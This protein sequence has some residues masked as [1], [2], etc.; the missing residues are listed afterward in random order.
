MNTLFNK[1]VLTALILGT[2]YFVGLEKMKAGNLEVGQTFPSF[3]KMNIEGVLPS[4]LSGKIVLVDFWASW[5]APCKKSFPVLE[6]LH[7][8]YGDKGVVVL[9]VNVDTNHQLMKKFLSKHAASFPIVR[10]AKH[11]L[12][13]SAGI[14]TMPSA[15]IIDDTGHVRFMH[16]GFHGD[17]TAQLYRSQ[18]ESL[19]N[20]K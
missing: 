14:K 1:V 3:Q 9:G 15:F 20:E 6:A 16:E 18:I 19:L 4:N 12:V 2:S 5:C 17:K 7:K 10:D 11:E 8:E 13:S